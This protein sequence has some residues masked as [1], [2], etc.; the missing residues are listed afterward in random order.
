MQLNLRC[1]TGNPILA[2]VWAS[3]KESR[4]IA[5]TQGIIS[6]FQWIRAIPMV[7]TVE[8]WD[9]RNATQDI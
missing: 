2:S 3:R 9:L 4:L 5:E 8:A 6:N 7:E 1:A